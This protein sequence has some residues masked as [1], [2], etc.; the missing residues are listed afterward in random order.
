MANFTYRFRWLVIIVSWLIAIGFALFIPRITID[1]EVEG[2]IPASMESKINTD[3]IED[4]FGGSDMIILILENKDILADSTLLRLQ[5][6]EAEFSQLPEIERTLSLFTMKD[7]KGQDG[8]MIVDPA[9]PGIP[10][11]DI[12][13]EAIRKS[14]AANDMVIGVVL[15]ADF[16]LA[17]II[18]SM[19]KETNDKDL[20]A[21]V[22]AIIQK[23]PGGEPVYLGGYPVVGQSITENILHDIKILLPLAFL[24]ILLVLGLAFRD[25][26]GVLLPLSVV[27]MSVLLTV[28]LIPLLG[29]KFSL[30]T[31]LLPIM[32]IAIGNNYG[33]YLVNRYQEIIKREPDIG[34]KVLL[35]K[36]SE[37]L[38]KPILVCALTT[39]AG[40]LALLTHIIVPAREV[41][42]LAAIGIA[43][44]LILSLFYIPAFL[45]VL[46]ISK[47]RTKNNKPHISHL[48]HFLFKTGVLI[49]KKPKAVLLVTVIITLII[50]SGMIRLKVEGN[51]IN[52]FSKK[53]PIRTT[54]AMIDKNFGG[55]QTLSIQFQG[56]IKDPALLGRM[57]L[58]ESALKNEKG[59]GQVLSIAS[60][61]K[62]MSKSLLD[63]GDPGY[64]QI[65][66][67]R[68][69]VAQYIELYSMSG[70]PA[71]FEQLVDFNY[72][73]AQMVIRINEA[74]SSTV[75]N[76]VKKIREMT[77]DDPMVARIG[78]IGLISAEMTDSLVT[79][80]WRSTA[81]AIVIVCLLVMWI[82]KAWRAGLMV[83]FPLG[84]AC[85]V[86][87]GIMGW[88][89]I[90]FD[91]AT[92]LI[93]SVMIGCGVD[94]TVQYLWRQRAE[95][96]AGRSQARAIVETLFTTGQAISFNALAVMIGF[97]P[98][99]FSS[100]SPIRFF[101]LMM[102][103]S[104]F[105][106]LIGALVIVPAIMMVWTPKFMTSSQ[107]PVTGYQLP[108]TSE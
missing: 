80:Q 61:I 15:S 63:P 86:L 32:M 101:G 108:G 19:Q 8:A 9:L 14:L 104:I 50:G 39:I 48:E 42:L 56:D 83:L 78:G 33:I 92:T 52:F 37:A 41:G 65:P 95:M 82:F 24:F 90:P 29:W 97:T 18:G 53:D 72:E 69:G 85:V 12:E 102:F 21:A 62:L 79:G 100:F 94:Y 75:L 40:V 34:K 93:T 89:G 58:Y 77:K 88:V 46:P 16:T 22:K 47:P 60:V 71:D 96:A 99:I 38:T 26:K 17:A 59:V 1:A 51:T 45:A 87:F 70:D 107:L 35:K 76:L 28:G 66:V 98:L 81:F 49:T 23:Y 54:S 11:S 30:V 43:W 2:L 73:N 5:N 67:T 55:S 10:S 27:L 7:I 64:N 3:K 31:V 4:Q 20:L 68:D 25:L 103:V 74:S 57:D 36:L 105:I 6:I 84:T 91:P 13:R 106:C 44:A